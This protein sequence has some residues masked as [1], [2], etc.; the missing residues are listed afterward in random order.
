MIATFKESLGVD[1]SGELSIVET[2]ATMD[3]FRRDNVSLI[4]TIPPRMGESLFNRMSEVFAEKPF[5]RAAMGVLV[6]E[7]F[8]VGRTSN[9][10]IARSSPAK[11][12]ASSI[13]CVRRV[14]ALSSTSGEQARITGCG[15]L[16]RQTR[17][18]CLIGM[19]RR[20]GPGLQAGHKLPVSAQ[21][22]IPDLV[23]SGRIIRQ[24][25]SPKNIFAVVA[26]PRYNIANMLARRQ[27]DTTKTLIPLP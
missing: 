21:P 19:T 10:R 6:R 26:K 27:A 16:T 9:R 11:P 5:S 8:G 24:G 25:R 4:K 17:A 18:R 1:I 12:S 15:Q 14:L 20:Q 13:L 2:Q 3:R 22:E 23:L 7:E